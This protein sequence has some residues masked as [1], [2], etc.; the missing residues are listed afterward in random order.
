MSHNR[1]NTSLK[2]SRRAGHPMAEYDRLPRHLRAWLSEAILPWRARSV[3]V[4]YDKA[5]A[6]TGSAK[7]ALRELDRLQ[8]T[9][10]SKDV[11]AVWGPE[12]PMLAPKPSENTSKLP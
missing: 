4:A 11:R 6:K 1:G 7:G 2:R 3:R 8:S 5:F 10:V 12:H 9:L